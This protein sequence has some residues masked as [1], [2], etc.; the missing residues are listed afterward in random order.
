MGLFFFLMF[1]EHCC[2][3]QIWHKLWSWMR[4]RPCGYFI[5]CGRSAY[6]FEEFEGDGAIRMMPREGWR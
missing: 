6:C 4:E 1:F 5:R 2:S 3:G